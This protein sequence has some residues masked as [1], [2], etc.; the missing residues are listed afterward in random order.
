MKKNGQTTK[1]NINNTQTTSSSCSPPNTSSRMQSF[2]GTKTKKNSYQNWKWQKPIFK[3]IN[4]NQNF[5]GGSDLFWPKVVIFGN[6]WRRRREGLPNKGL[7][8]RLSALTAKIGFASKC[9]LE[10]NKVLSWN[11]CA[12][13]QHHRYLS[14]LSVS[15][16]T[17]TP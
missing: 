14:P 11:V 12:I 7:R 3:T 5:F 16:I 17:I 6:H 15:S 4:K 10:E 2:K 13:H 9:S 8:S 1:F